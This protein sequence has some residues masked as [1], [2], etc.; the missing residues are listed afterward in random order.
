MCSK[1]LL[2]HTHNQSTNQTI[3][4]DLRIINL[5]LPSFILLESD[6]FG[7]KA[8]LIIRNVYLIDAMKDLINLMTLFTKCPKKT[9]SA[10]WNGDVSDVSLISLYSY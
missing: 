7:C 8:N 1:D 6:H 4:R 2:F 10:L 3:D 9:S 5:G